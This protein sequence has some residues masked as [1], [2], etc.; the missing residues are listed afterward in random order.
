MRSESV[1]SERA[2]IQAECGVEEDEPE[3]SSR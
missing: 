1:S 2:I 3:A